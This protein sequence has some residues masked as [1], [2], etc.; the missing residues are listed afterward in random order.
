MSMPA[1]GQG[2]V[3]AAFPDSRYDRRHYLAA[4]E[5]RSGREAWRTPIDCE[6]ITAPV[7]ADDHIYLTN[8]Q[9]TLLCFRAEGGALVWRAAKDAT[10][11]PMVWNREC[12]FSQRRE[13]SKGTEANREQYQTECV[14][15]RGVE[16]DA[17]THAYAGTVRVAHYLDHAKRMTGSLRYRTSAMMDA[18]VGFSAHKGDAKMHLA[19]KHLG[20]GHVHEVWAYQG[21]KPFIHRGRLYSA[22]GDSLHCLDPVTREVCWKKRLGT[23]LSEGEMLDSVL[24]PPATVNGKLFISSIYG[25]IYCLAAA[26]GDEL[27]TARVGEAIVFPP[28]VARGRIYIPTDGGNLYCLETGDEGDDGWYMWGAT[29]AHNGLAD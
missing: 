9:G 12:Y 28:A 7:L 11:S 24:T 8:L 27:W 5:L 29:A 19:M 6:V 10:S 22:L 2:H 26:S 4:F 21:S 1:V 3:Y 20:R 14:A 25:D 16:S 13:E 23:N 17:A 15:A 18:K